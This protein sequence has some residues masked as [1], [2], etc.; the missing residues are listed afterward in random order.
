[1]AKP[2]VFVL[3]REQTQRIHLPSE[4]SGTNQGWLLVEDI[5]SRPHNAVSFVVER[6]TRKYRNGMGQ[7]CLRHCLA[8]VEVGCQEEA[9]KE[10]AEKR[11]RKR[12]TAE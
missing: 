8:T 5:E 11:R 4:R 7:S 9:Q 12:R 2:K 3:Q 10:R 6:E 1:M